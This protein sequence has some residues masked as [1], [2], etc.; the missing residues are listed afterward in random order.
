MKRTIL[1]TA[2]CM[3][4]LLLFGQKNVTPKSAK[5]VT[6]VTVSIPDQPASIDPM[7]Y[8]QMLEDCN[9]RVI[10]GGVVGSTGQPN[11]AVTELLKPLNMPVMRWPG[12]TYVDEY[13]WEK[14][15]GDVSKRPVIHAR[16]WGQVETNQF[17]TDEFLEWCR[18][19]GTEPYINF[20]MGWRV[21]PES[22]SLGDA[23]NWIEYVNGSTSTAFGKKRALYGHPDPYD[24]KYWGM[25]NENYFFESAAHYGDRLHR[26]ATTIKSLYPELS[27]IGVGYKYRWNDSILHQNGHLIDF[28]TIH[29]YMR[30]KVKENILED[31][32][33]TTFA[34]ARVE[35]DLKKNIE[36]LDRINAELGRTANPVRYSIDEW[37]CRHSVFDGEK[38]AFTRHDDR[39]QFDIPTVAG[40]LN[41]FIRQSPAVGMA[42]YIFP[43]N[44]HGLVRTTSDSDAYRTPTYYV[45]E[46][47]RKY[48][49][50]HRFDLSITG[51]T[52]TVPVKNL[53]VEGATDREFESLDLTLTNIDGA[54]MQPEEGVIYVA[55]INRSPDESHRIKLTLPA[56]YIPAKIWKLESNNINSTNTLANPIITPQTSELKKR[57]ETLSLTIL[58]CGF[59]LIKCI[60]S[61]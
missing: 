9:D 45:F 46:L 1:I 25:G 28:L 26:W 60:K 55:L 58:P 41:V 52:V 43:V 14:G 18:E 19:V 38:F 35:L 31:S 21:P 3:F 48:M 8:G 47:Y 42:N 5:T 54:A 23:L 4:G 12:G 57:S 17:G 13:D 61:R 56:S 29:F 44:G 10:Y 24:V 15:I 30:A 53:A 40:M 36:L 6:Q 27:L 50:G 22:G 20:N 11:P 39:R 51:S 7:I 37:N 49:T 2:G 16:Q 59:N 32:L 34:P 33:S